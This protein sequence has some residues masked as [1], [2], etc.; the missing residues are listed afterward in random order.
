M[1]PF[2]GDKYSDAAKSLFNVLPEAAGGL[3]PEQQQN[4]QARRNF[5]SAVL[6]KES[7]AS[8]SPTEY[9]NEEKKYFPQLGDSDQVIK[10]KQNSRIKAI[11]GLKSQ[12]GPSGVRQINQITSQAQGGGGVVDF[13]SLP[14]GR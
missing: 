6:R 10:Q 4:A 12:A 9:A 7:G 3:S 1:M 11:E 5:I 2:V 14:K 13:N 8:I